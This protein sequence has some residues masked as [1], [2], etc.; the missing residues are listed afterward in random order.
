M[1]MPR[2][3]AEASLYRA[4]GRYA[5]DALQRPTNRRARS[6]ASPA[7]SVDETLPPLHVRPV[8]FQINCV[9]HGGGIYD[10]SV[11]SYKRRE[12]CRTSIWGGDPCHYTAAGCPAGGDIVP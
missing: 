8:H 6:A 10:C 4:N 7:R 3:T 2:F 1:N 11:E 9:D 12:C 5:E